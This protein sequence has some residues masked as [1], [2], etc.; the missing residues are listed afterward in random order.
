MRPAAI[1]VLTVVLTLV[2][3]LADPVESR[4][5]HVRPHHDHPTL[6]ARRAPHT[7][8]RH[9]RPGHAARRPEAW[10][11]P[12]TVTP[13]I[14]RVHDGDTF[15][16]GPVTIR[17]HG[18][19]TPEL[20]EPKAAEATRRLVELLRAGPV[21]IVPRAEDVYGRLVADVFVRGQNVADV[22]R[23]EG[24]EKPRPRL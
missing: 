14:I 3:V 12:F 11:P 10:G 1:S 17:L 21:T 5:R 19:D 6:H 22:L 9:V 8:A 23:R 24:F 7:L 15:Y 4:P 18:I 20:G 2:T 16:A 13:D